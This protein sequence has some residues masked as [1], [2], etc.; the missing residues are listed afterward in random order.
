MPKNSGDYF[1]EMN[2]DYVRT[3]EM[4]WLPIT[5][6]SDHGKRIIEF[7]RAE[8][9]LPRQTRRFVLTVEMNGLIVVDC[10]Y[11]PERKA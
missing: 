9:G 6:S 1:V 11:L 10:E 7:M 3:D 5:V 8:L 4:S 2:D